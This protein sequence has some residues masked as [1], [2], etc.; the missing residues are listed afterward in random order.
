MTGKL[1]HAWVVAWPCAWHVA[2]AVVVV[3]MWMMWWGWEKCMG[4][5]HGLVRL[6]FGVGSRLIGDGGEGFIVVSFFE[7]FLHIF[8]KILIC[9]T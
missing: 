6:D 5:L 7:P 1:G 2:W 3:M 9:F 8:A 4:I